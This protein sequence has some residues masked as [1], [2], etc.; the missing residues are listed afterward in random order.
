MRS[1]S[2]ALAERIESTICIYQPLLTMESKTTPEQYFD[3]I[4]FQ[5]LHDTLIEVDG[6]KKPSFF[7]V[8]VKGV[9][10]S[11]TTRVLKPSI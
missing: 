1:A 11:L 2:P 10:P 4:S 8:K 3:K 7:I 6:N 9:E 5:T